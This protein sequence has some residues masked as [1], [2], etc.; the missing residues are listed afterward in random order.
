MIDFFNQQDQARRTTSLLVVLFVLAVCALILLTNLL[1]MVT[2]WGVTGLSDGSLSTLLYQGSGALLQ[3]FDWHRFGLISLAVSGTVL[4]AIVYKWFQLAEGGKAVAE[5]LGGSRIQPNCDSAEQQRALNV[6][7]EMALASGMPVPSV[8]LLDNEE[9]INAFAAGNTPADAVIGLTRGTIERLSRPQLQGVVAHEFSH[10]LNG[11][12]RLNLRLIAILHGIVFIGSVGELLLHFGSSGSRRNSGK[13]GSPHLSLLGFGL[14]IVGWIGAFF[15]R[16]IKA[17]VSR[18]REFLADASAVQFTRNPQGIADALKVIGGHQQGALMANPNSDTLSHLFFGQSL[19]RLTGLY[20][21]HPP[22]L[23]RIIKLQPDW[24]GSYIYPKP[25]QIKQQQQRDQQRQE[26]LRQQQEQRRKQALQLGVVLAGGKIANDLDRSLVGDSPLQR[27]RQGID[28]LPATIHSQIHEPLGAM[29]VV[30]SLIIS[31]LEEVQARQLLLIEKQPVT[32]I[33]R[34]CRQLRPDITQLPRRHHLP[35]AQLC[36]P[37]LKC[38]SPEQYPMFKKTLLLLIRADQQTDLFEW[39]LYQVVQHYLAAE[40]E[41][42]TLRAG[43]HKQPQQL[44]DQ[45][46]LVMSLLAHHGHTDPQEAERGFNRGVA[47]VGLYNL[48]LLPQSDCALPA[49]IKAVSALAD[50]RPLLKSRLLRGLEFCIKQDKQISA[51]EVEIISAIAAVMD[52]PQPRL[53]I[54]ARLSQ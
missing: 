42:R 52:C 32:G 24:N 18:Q 47:S 17:S 14:L 48:R 33:S 49:F 37:A 8:Y 12:M 23:E 36:L 10:I 13:S 5:S 29:A 22:L 40:F 30:Y 6:V 15:G 51:V 19:Q 27:V 28:A 7:E 1:V 20:A 4:S 44:A 34:L 46:Q 45:Y 54:D 11:D 31:D 9:G 26:H 43:S 2:L 21:T 39:C 16:L 50:S 38:I 35:L 25:S 3:Q 41:N 53:P